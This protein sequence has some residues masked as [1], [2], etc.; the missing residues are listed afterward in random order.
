MAKKVQKRKKV[1]SRLEQSSLIALISLVFST[2]IGVL[3]IHN[4]SKIAR[5]DEEVYI[6][7]LQYSIGQDSSGYLY[8][9]VLNTGATSANKVVI[10]ISWDY[11]IELENCSVTQPYQDIKPVQPLLQ[12]G[13]TFR[14]ETLPVDGYFNISCECTSSPVGGITEIAIPLSRLATALYTT[15]TAQSFTPTLLLVANTIRVKVTAD[16]SRAAIDIGQ[17]PQLIEAFV[18]PTVTPQPR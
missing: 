5:L 11:G 6:P 15:D 8:I 9:K 16:N 2:L 10:D 4:S 17:Y 12:R 13:L 3:S 7:I 14:L 18:S 1:V